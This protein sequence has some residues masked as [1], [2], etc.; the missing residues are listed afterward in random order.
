MEDTIKKIKITGTAA[1][2]IVGAKSRTRKVR[3]HKG[4]SNEAPAVPK[5]VISFQQAQPPAPQAPLPL[6]PPLPKVPEQEGGVAKPVK[7][8]LAPSSKKKTQHVVLS[9]PKKVIKVPGLAVEDGHKKTH[10]VARRIRV[11]VA[12]MNKRLHRAK[13]IKKESHTMPIEKMK[14][15]LV[16][17]SLIKADSKAPEAILRSMYSDFQ[18]LKQRAL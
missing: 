18:M 7:V 8:I 1:D 3:A 13:T 14:G 6:A 17:A 16:A 5:P 2:G 15:E 12:G 4:G 11:S 9:Q 10:K